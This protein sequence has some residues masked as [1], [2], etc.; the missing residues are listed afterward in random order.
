M[1]FTIGISHHRVSNGRARRARLCPGRAPGH[2][3]A[4]LFKKL[5]T[6]L[7][8]SGLLEFHLRGRG[9]GG[10]GGVAA[11]AHHQADVRGPTCVLGVVICSLLITCMIRCIFRYS[12]PP[13]T[14]ARL[15]H[16]VLGDA[17]LRAQW[18]DECR[19]MADRI[20]GARSTLREELEKGGGSREWSHVTSQIGM[21]AFTGL[22]AEQCAEMISK[23]HIYLTSDGRVSMAGVTRSNA[24]YIAEAMCAVTAG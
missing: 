24:G 8:P 23:H 20:I 7:G 13:A 17:T 22:T 6:V 10:A 15:V 21:F 5:W 18:T 14:G 16:T 19:A 9:R 11:Q 4:E 2:V 1:I 3:H 12:N